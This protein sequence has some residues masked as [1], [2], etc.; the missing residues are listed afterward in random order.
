MGL[1]AQLRT[2]YGMLPMLRRAGRRDLLVWLR[3]RPQLLA[4]TAVYETAL[5]TSGRMDVRLKYLAE[6][7]SAALVNCEF[8]LDIGSAMAK[9]AGITDDQLRALPHYR[10]SEVFDAD[11]KLVL[12]FAEAVSGTPA[13]VPEE[14]RCALVERFSEAAVAEL[15]AAIA[16]ENNR[17]RLNQALGVRPEGFTTDG[18]C[19]LPETR[20]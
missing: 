17:G 5:V 7:K 19:A 3:R 20:V 16:W 10:D 8:C 14:L 13:H 9:L 6:L 1:G 15:A 4:A 12:Q 2:Y 18:F 11:E